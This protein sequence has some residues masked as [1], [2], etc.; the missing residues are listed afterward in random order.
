MRVVCMP[1]DIVSET[2]AEFRLMREIRFRL[3]CVLKG[4]ADAALVAWSDAERDR[5][6]RSKRWPW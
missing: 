1:R 4:F 3:Y 2:Y 5:V 6:Q